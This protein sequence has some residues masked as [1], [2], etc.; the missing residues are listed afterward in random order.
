MSLILQLIHWISGVVV[1]A[2]ALNKLERTRPFVRGVTIETLG[3]AGWFLVAMGAGGAAIT[4][5]L[6]AFGVRSDLQTIL[7]RLERPT[8]AEVAVML[9]FACLVLR[10]RFKEGAAQPHRR[11][12]DHI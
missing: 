9:G 2:E 12:G 3:A 5:V 1:L 8:L 10:A 6:L 11:I 4:P 7:M